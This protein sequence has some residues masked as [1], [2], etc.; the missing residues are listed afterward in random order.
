MLQIMRWTRECE[1]RTDR[2]F[3]GEA[4]LVELFGACSHVIHLLLHH[5]LL[6]VHVL[7]RLAQLSNTLLKTQ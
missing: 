1:R 7:E 4:F 5:V 3:R 6:E 2:F